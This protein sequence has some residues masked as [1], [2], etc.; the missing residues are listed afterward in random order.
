MIK[1]DDKQKLLVVATVILILIGVG[2]YF[3]INDRLNN[4]VYFVSFDSN[5]GSKVNGQ[6]VKINEYVQKPMNPVRAGYDFVYW[7]LYDEEY[8]FDTPV[9][10]NLTLVAKWEKNY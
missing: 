6:S 3:V 1:S 8:N 4:T 9:K 7:M 10:N 5:G 2:I